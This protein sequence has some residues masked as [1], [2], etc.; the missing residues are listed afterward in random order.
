MTRRS[1]SR[2]LPRGAAGRSCGRPRCRAGITFLEIVAGSVLLAIVGAGIFSMLNSMVASQWRQQQQLAASE[3]ASRMMILYLDDSFEM[4]NRSQRLDW[5]EYRFR[6]DYREEPMEFLEIGKDSR[7]T[8]RTSGLTQDRYKLI[9]VRV[10][11]SEES[12][13]NAGFS[14]LIPHAVITRPLDP[15]AIRNPDAFERLTQDPA[16]YAEYIAM[17]SG[18][19]PA[20]RGAGESGRGGRS[21]GSSGSSRG[22]G[23]GPQR[24][25]GG[26]SSGRG[27][28]STGG[29]R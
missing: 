15:F 20:G 16:R 10:W 22:S 21:G 17:M 26:T 25:A 14:E 5:G 4:P 28:T 6:W 3:L 19:T 18:Q 2:R 7:S 9:T 29:R 12:G 13:G 23:G 24:D 11:L 27:G 1:P 8:K